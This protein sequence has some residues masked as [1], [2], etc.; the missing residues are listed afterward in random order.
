[1][2]LAASM[3][4]GCAGGFSL[5]SAGIFVP[6]ALGGPTG[7]GLSWELQPVSPGLV[8]AQR[9]HLATAPTPCSCRSD[10]CQKDDGEDGGPEDPPGAE[11]DDL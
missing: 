7:E 4:V 11:E 2:L 10:V 9:G 6:S 3:A 8:W 1:M 5:L